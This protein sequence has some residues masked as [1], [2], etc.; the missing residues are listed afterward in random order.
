MR[1]QLSFWCINFSSF[2]FLPRNDDVWSYCNTIFNFMRTSIC[3]STIAALIYISI[4][5]IELFHFLYLS[6]RF[7][8][9][10]FK[11]IT[12]IWFL[13]TI[14]LHNFPSPFP[15]PSPFHICCPLYFLSDSCP[16]FPLLL[17]HVYQL[18]KTIC[19]Y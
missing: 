11:V 2:G 16:F 1:V 18:A 19:L 10:F 5:Y 8:S 15:L 17:L 14:W 13:I 7:S 9:L 12:Y 4:S 3:L 6:Q